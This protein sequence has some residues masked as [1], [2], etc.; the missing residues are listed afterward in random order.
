M[1]VREFDSCQGNVSRL[2]GKNLVQESVSCAD[3]RILPFT[4]FHFYVAVDDR[5]FKLCI[6][7]IWNLSAFI[8]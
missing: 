5:T 7:L 1:S 2:S 3:S 6:Y 4:I 8:V